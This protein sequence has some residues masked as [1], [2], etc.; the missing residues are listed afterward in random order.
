MFQQFKTFMQ[1]K[2]AVARDWHEL[3]ADN[4][5][6]G[7]FA[8]EV[9]ALLLGKNKPSYT[10]NVDGG[11]YVVVTNAEKITV[12]REKAKKKVYSWHSGIPGGFKQF[13][14]AEMLARNP[15]KV[16]RHA[17][18]NMLPKNRLRSE[19]MKRLK[20]VIGSEHPYKGMIKAN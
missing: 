19:R 9:A 20:I 18:Q 7:R 5:V 16:M 1:K 11:D 2:E 17:V 8:S 4:K 3:D 14:F 15:E 6:L 13:T 12:T 10:P